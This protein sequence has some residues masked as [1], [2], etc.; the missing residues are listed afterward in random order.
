[1]L[2]HKLN[3]LLKLYKTA[4]RNENPA[5]IEH[6]SQQLKKV[7][8]KVEGRRLDPVSQ[9]YL[10]SLHEVH[11]G[12]LCNADDQIELAIDE[13]ADYSELMKVRSRAEAL[14]EEMASRKLH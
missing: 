13:D 14:A 10:D 5:A 9:L 2:S 7:L 1:M 12:C 8:E 6:C 3:N 11:N 4:S